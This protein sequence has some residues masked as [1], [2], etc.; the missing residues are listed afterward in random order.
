MQ[1]HISW[2][3]QASVPLSNELNPQISYYDV[4]IHSFTVM[5]FVQVPVTLVQPGMALYN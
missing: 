1:K 3:V 2:Q 5:L 4:T